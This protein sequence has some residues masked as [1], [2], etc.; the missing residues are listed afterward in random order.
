MNPMV[1]IKRMENG[2][3]FGNLLATGL[4]PAQSRTLLLRAR[5]MSV[6]DVATALGCSP[7]NV[8]NA[9]RILFYKLDCGNAP[10][11]ITRAFENGLLRILSLVL[12][13]Y[14]SVFAGAVNDDTRR[15]R[16]DP[17]RNASRLARRT[18]NGRHDLFWDEDTHRFLIIPEA[19]N[20]QA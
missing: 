8:K 15:T 3:R 11:L 4:P 5:G 16:R 19:L 12:A 17:P 14:I 18:G 1:D 2:Y 13:V 6:E 9:M 7:Q 20:D 10:A